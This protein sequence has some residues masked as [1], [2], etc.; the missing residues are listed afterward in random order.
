MEDAHLS[1]TLATTSQATQYHK[2]E[3]HKIKVQCFTP[4]PLGD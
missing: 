4:T 1:Q 3:D 2:P